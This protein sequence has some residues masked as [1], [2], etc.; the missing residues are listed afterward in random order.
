MEELSGK[1]IQELKAMAYDLIAALEAGQKRLQ[2]VNQEIVG[3][4]RLQSLEPKGE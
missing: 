3:I 1:S 2:Q 4:E